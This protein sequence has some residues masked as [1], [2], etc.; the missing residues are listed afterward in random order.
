[1]SK[2]LPEKLLLKPGGSLLLVHPPLGYADRL[3]SLPEG[4]EVVPAG[5][6]DVVQFFCPDQAGLA[7]HVDEALAALVP[8]G[9]LWCCYPKQSA[10]VATDLTRDR[11]WEGLTRRGWQVVSAISVDDV[12]SGLRFMPAR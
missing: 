6:A 3:G 11:G 7:G 8:N 1:M 2:T 9:V 12:W 10:K 4:A 5:P